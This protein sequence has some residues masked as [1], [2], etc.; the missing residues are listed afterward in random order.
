MQNDFGSNIIQLGIGNK[1]FV[2]QYPEFEEEYSLLTDEDKNEG[3]N[4]LISESET[5]EEKIEKIKAMIKPEASENEGDQQ[6]G[7][8]E[9]SDTLMADITDAQYTNEMTMQEAEHESGENADITK[10]SPTVNADIL[11]ETTFQRSEIG[12]DQYNDEVENTE[13]EYQFPDTMPIKRQIKEEITSENS[14]SSKCVQDM[15]KSNE[16]IKEDLIDIEN[17]TANT[18]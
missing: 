8:M 18:V 17:D 3:T 7:A 9:A 15:E 13:L 12:D 16:G 5:V 10:E 4:G 1:N 14:E 11:N 6:E 2:T